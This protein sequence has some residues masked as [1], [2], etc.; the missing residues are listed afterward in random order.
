[1]AV[2]HFYAAFKAVFFR[3]CLLAFLLRHPVLYSTMSMNTVYCYRMITNAK[4]I[5][6]KQYDGHE[7]V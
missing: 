1:M 4:E 3:T 7:K 2:L 6:K 5:I